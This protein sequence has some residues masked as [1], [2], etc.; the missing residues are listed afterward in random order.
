MT[1]PGGYNPKQYSYGTPAQRLPPPPMWGG[2][3]EPPFQGPPGQIPGPPQPPQE[4]GGLEPPFPPPGQI[5]GPPGQVTSGVDPYVPQPGYTTGIPGR[6]TTKDNDGDGYIPPTAP[7]AQP[8]AAPGATP[9]TTPST[10][11]TP[12]PGTAPAPGPQ[13]FGGFYRPQ[14]WGGIPFLQ[15]YGGQPAPWDNILTQVQSLRDLYGQG[16][17][18]FGSN[19]AARYG[20]QGGVQ[21]WRPDANPWGQPI[22]PY[23]YN[24]QESGLVRPPQYTLPGQPPTGGGSPPPAAPPA[25]PPAAPPAAQDHMQNLQRMFAENPQLALRSTFMGGMQPWFQQNQG[26]VR[27]RLFGGDQD[28]MNAWLNNNGQSASSGWSQADFDALRRYGYTGY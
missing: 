13:S 24:P 9:G 8:P 23:Q 22:Q 2:G 6:V 26:A 19:A 10:A 18:R 7:Y 1:I 17:G 16:A 28:R 4:G 14:P 3:V 20:F 11:G 12:P 25:T 15:T 5:P 21:Q 27:D